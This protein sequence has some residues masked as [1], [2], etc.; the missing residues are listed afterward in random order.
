MA[1]SNKKVD[2]DT[3]KAVPNTKMKFAY[4]EQNIMVKGDSIKKSKN[5]TYYFRVNIGYDSEKDS[6]I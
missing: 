1:T 5:G 3:G 6:E 2:H 4:K